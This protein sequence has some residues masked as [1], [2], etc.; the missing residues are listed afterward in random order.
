VSVRLCSRC[1]GPVAHQDIWNDAHRYFP[2]CVFFLNTVRKAAIEVAGR[3]WGTSV[4]ESYHNLRMA[5]MDNLRAL[6][7]PALPPQGGLNKEEKDSK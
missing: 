4:T 2:D 1:G 6:L 3:D 7:K 5:S